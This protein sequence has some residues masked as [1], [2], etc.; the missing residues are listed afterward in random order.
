MVQ[1][2][3]SGVEPVHKQVLDAASGLAIHH[4]DRAN[5]N[6]YLIFVGSVEFTP[7]D[8]YM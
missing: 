1:K 2:P 3:L 8:H 5:D 4:T 6:E 7:Q